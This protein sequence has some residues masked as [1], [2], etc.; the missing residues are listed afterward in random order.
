MNPFRFRGKLLPHVLHLVVFSVSLLRGWG[1]AK[2]EGA[3][4]WYHLNGNARD[5]LSEQSGTLIG[6]AEYGLGISGDGVRV[7][8]GGYVQLGWD[9]RL[10]RQ[11]FTIEAWVRRR[12]VAQAG[13]HPLGVGVIFGG[14]AKGY[15]LVLTREGQLYMSH[16]GIY[17]VYATG[18]I[19]DTEWHHVAMVR[20]GT[21]LRFYIDGQPAGT[22]EY[23]AQFEFE[24]PYGIG[25]IGTPYDG[26]RYPFLGDIDEVAVYQRPLSDAEVLAAYEATERNVGGVCYPKPNG[27]VAWWPGDAGATDLIGVS[28]GKLSDGATV[29]E[30]KVENSFRFN[31]GASRVVI[32][33]SSELELQDLT[34]EMWLKRSN[35]SLTSDSPG[36]AALFAGEIGNY[37]MAIMHGGNLGFAKVGIDRLDTPPR[38]QDLEWHH[39]A[40]TK[41]GTTVTFYVDGRVTDVMTYNGVFTF[42]GPYGIG[43]QPNPVTEAYFSFLGSL[44][45]VTVYDRPLS[46]TEVEWIWLAGS[47]GK[48]RGGIRLTLSAPDEVVDGK[49]FEFVSTVANQGTNTLSNVVVTNRIPPGFKVGF[50]QTTA[51]TATTESGPEGARVIF[52]AVD[53]PP[54]AQANAQVSLEQSP[55]G[56]FTLEATA[57]SSEDSTPVAASAEILVRPECVPAATGLSAWWRGEGSAWDEIAGKEGSISN[58]VSFVEGRVGNAFRFDGLA[59]TGVNLGRVPALQRSEFTIE[60][61]LRRASAGSVSQGGDWGN[62][63]GADFGGWTFLLQRDG[64]LVFGRSDISSV[65]TSPVLVD[66]AWHHVAVAKTATEVRF[67]VDGQRVATRPYVETFNL[68]LD[69]G[70]GATF[71]SGRNAF[72]GE[73]DE[74]AFYS[75]I[76]D[77]AEIAA[78]PQAGGAPKC[79]ND[80]QVNAG[81]TGPVPVGENW[82]I[83]IIV[84]TKGTVDSTQVRLT[85]AIPAGLLLVS[86]TSTQGTI[87]NLAGLLRADL[88]TIPARSNAVVTIVV[89]PWVEGVYDL[90]VNVGRK[91]AELTDFNNSTTIRGTAVRLT[92]SLEGDVT[93]TEPNEAEFAVV[94]NAPMIKTVTVN[95]ATEAGSATA[96]AD[97][98]SKS[99]VLEF[100]PGVVR[101]TIKVPVVGDGLYELDESFALV[102]SQPVNAELGLARASGNIVSPDPLPVVRV[103]SVIAPEGNAGPTSF[104]FEFELDR[105]SGLAARLH[106]AT[107]NDTAKAPT[108][109][110]ATE[111]TLEFPP[112][113]T[114]A[115]VNVTV[116]GDTA[117][118]PNEMFLLAL[119]EPQGLRFASVPPAPAVG[120]IVNEDAVAGLVTSFR[121][122]GLPAIVDAG[123]PFPA[124]I[125]ALDGFLNAV[126]GFDGVVGVQAYAGP[127]SP[128]QVILTE[129]AI[130][131]GRGVELQNVSGEPVDVSGWKVY[132]YDLTLWP[133]PKYTVTIPQGTSV[134][135]SEVF[136]IEVGQLSGPGIY[137]RF[138]QTG[139]LRWNDRGVLSDPRPVVVGVVVTDADGA[140]EDTFFAGAADPR[141]V[142]IPTVL[143]EEDWAGNPVADQAAGIGF[144]R[145]SGQS[146]NQR[147][148]TDWRV[149]SQNTASMN[150]GNPGLVLPFVDS[151][152]LAVSPDGA[153]G[154]SGGLWTGNLTL[155]GYAS[156]VRLVADDGNGHRSLSDSFAVRVADD[157][158][159]AM[160][161]D[162][163]VV[164]TP[165]WS[166]EF[167]VAV[168]NLGPVLSS[169]VTARVLLSPTYG[170]A[171]SSI[172]GLPTVTQGTVVVRTRLSPT[173]GPQ[174]EIIASFGDLPAGGVA[175]LKIRAAKTISTSGR[176][177][178]LNLESTVVLSRDPV[179]LNLDNNTAT[180]VQ[181]LSNP[182]APLAPLAVAWWAGESGYTDLLGVLTGSVDGVVGAGVPR[183][184]SASWEFDGV[185]G[186]IRV[187]DSP[188]LN[189]G[190]NESF[191]LEFWM[192][193]PPDAG[194]SLAVLG[195]E[196]T[197]G[198]GRLGYAV[199]VEQGGLRFRIGDGSDQNSWSF[200]NPV[201][202]PGDLRDGEWDPV[203][204][205]V[206]RG[207]GATIRAT[208]DAQSYFGAG[209]EPFARSIA[210]DAPL[211]FGEAAPGSPEGRFKGRLDE[212]VIYRQLVSFEQSQAAF[213]AG[214]HGHCRSEFVVEP[215]R[216]RSVTNAFGWT[217]TDPGVAGQPYRFDFVLRNRGPLASPVSFWVYPNSTE[218]NLYLLTL[219]G[220]VPFSPELGAAKADLSQPQSPGQELPFAVYVT[221]TNP[222]VSLILFGGGLGLPQKSATAEVVINLRADTDG[223][224]IPDEVET[225]AGMNPLSSADAA[226]DVDGDGYSA[227]AEFD[228]GT[229]PNDANSVL[230]L[231]IVDGQVVV[232]AVASRVYRLEYRADLGAGGWVILKEV[233]PDS[234]GVLTVGPIGSGAEPL[235]YRVTVVQPYAETSG[236]G[237]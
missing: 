231:R 197:T 199:T 145:P 32:S 112:G 193:I 183:V 144:Y 114:V 59:G 87:E 170:S 79:V 157:L 203:T 69:Y 171:I 48:C 169:N 225:A 209:V 92:V 44:D 185:Q 232:D 2:P 228:A 57:V 150:R 7:E 61:W 230:R 83:P 116:N 164:T 133:A 101:Q 142:G 55:L 196:V 102:L 222:V 188:A 223:D 218:T 220:S 39:V 180:V 53:L 115:T 103:R 78:I 227:G 118:E 65:A 127:G 234:D 121:W 187:P 16:V 43:A 168:T 68:E 25:A 149:S 52:K 236:L 96:G 167:V 47:A 132:F 27:A 147:R 139:T 15:S 89:R 36:G 178:P 174:P 20:A 177:V 134:R 105:A 191:S 163:P 23:V 30:G 54:G 86:A 173:A 100:S 217:H 82:E 179:E 99:G 41:D 90:P 117:V 198:T 64:S 210:N 72:L 33:D 124:Q 37:G 97:F 5:S 204:T 213:R 153:S 130:S 45:E 1:A 9:H 77:D 215:V 135:P 156:Q 66:V 154:F 226:S 194:N 129:I 14:S 73:L 126:P 91:E 21:T 85:N 151:V 152:P 181:E 88:G 109:F 208:I 94:L 237:N 214:A 233:R 111:G 93:T 62:I 108:D 31:G 184:G 212:V 19:I 148:A 22:V 122:Q 140:V 155:N 113:Q 26:E 8:A 176:D 159:V 50:I 235:Y 224:G 80:L 182:C 161:V 63:L 11:E 190:T 71:P 211:R 10:D 221:S 28:E 75:R 18:R 216:P 165:N 84:T 106:Y 51:G 189:F 17:S 34:I 138:R 146:R 200:G 175:V 136:T 76:L 119:S 3:I 107:T 205:S 123:T 125:Q 58:G 202:Q 162:L 12:N 56:R 98:E 206:Q 104:G 186:A 160:T 46:P 49:S 158:T 74:I 192:S 81:G 141:A 70:I 6:G 95:Y 166:S 207:E 229:S 137:P 195:K 219:D 131:S 120:T 67:F 24:G 143:R 35:V 110:V 40:V 4:A 29:G 128:S 60:G 172:I 13:V 42:G 201:G 38:I